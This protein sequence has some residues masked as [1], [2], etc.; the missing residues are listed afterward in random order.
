MMDAISKSVRL[1]NDDALIVAAG[2][3]DYR[4]FG[5][6]SYMDIVTAAKNTNS[7]V[8]MIDTAIKDGKN[9]FDAMSIDELTE[10]IEYAHNSGLK[11]ALAGSIKKAHLRNLI[12]LKPDIIGI[13]GAV[14]ESD[15]RGNQISPK[16][17]EEF[18][19]YAVHL[20]SKSIA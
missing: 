4:R 19:N 5:G 14:C 16:K 18:L 2:Y 7:D 11:V 3:A 1:V 12:D 20:Q 8:V 10:F 17:V 6:L 9:L 13:R 15:N